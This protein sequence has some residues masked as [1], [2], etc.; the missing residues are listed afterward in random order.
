MVA[1]HI[2]L[3]AQNQRNGLVYH[4]IGQE[5]HCFLLVT[6]STGAAIFK[7]YRTTVNFKSPLL[8]HAISGHIAGGFL[9]MVI[10][11]KI[12]INALRVATV[13]S[14]GSIKAGAITCQLRAYAIV[15]LRAT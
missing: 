14:D 9:A 12:H 15:N 10:S 13:I 1:L 4:V 7:I 11:N 6:G 3:A 8:Q 2:L 5:Q